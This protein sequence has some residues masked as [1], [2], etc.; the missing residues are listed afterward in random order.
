MNAEII[1]KL[2]TGFEPGLKEEL[3]LNSE[4]LNFVDSDE[5]FSLLLQR[6]EAM[7]GAREFF[8]MGA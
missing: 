5:D 4:N 2:Y 7:R 8:S 6:I 3:I 1:E